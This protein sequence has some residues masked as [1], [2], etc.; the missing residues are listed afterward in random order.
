MFG[1]KYVVINERTLQS[2]IDHANCWGYGYHIL[3]R[4]IV[5][6]D[7]WDKFIFSNILRVLIYNGRTEEAKRRTGRMGNV[8][9]LIRVVSVVF[10]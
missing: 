8:S 2:H 1:N 5:G 7:Q 9:L 3:R 10:H 6:A 4:E